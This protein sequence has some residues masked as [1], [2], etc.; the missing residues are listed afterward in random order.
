M[1]DAALIRDVSDK[2][3]AI[4][5]VWI[6]MSDGRRLAARLWLPRDAERNPVPAILEYIPYR[7]RD[8]TRPRDE[9]MHPW[10]AAQGYACARVDIAGSGD[11]D[12]LLLDEYLVSEQDDACEIIA[13][14]AAQPWCSGAVGM[15]G[16]SWGGFNGLQVAARRPPA[17]KAVI[18]LCSTVDR[19]ADDVH[20]M[21]GCLLNDNMDWGGAFFAYAALPPDPAM[22][23]PDWRR[24]W[25]ERLEALRPFPALW[26]EHQRRDAFWRHG[27]VCEDYAAIE[28][29]VL[30]VSG[31]ADGYTA[32]VF[33][34]VENLK[35]P[36]KGI[37]GPWGHLYP[38]RG[39]PGPAIGFLQ[40]AVRW[41]DRWLKNRPTGV[42]K[43][44]A[45]RLW[46][47]EGVAPQAHYDVRPGRWIGL[48]RWPSP[49]IVV[50][51]LALNAHGLA[52]KPEAAR[53]LVLCSPQTTGLAAGEWCAYGLGKVAP[54]MPLDQRI[55]DAGSLVFDSE[56]LSEPLAVVGAPRVTLELASDRPQA[57][58]AVRLSDVA[59]DGAATRVAYGLLNLS[60]RDSHAE[61]TALEPGRRYRVNV[62]L[63][64]AAYLFAPGRRLRISISTS[65][66]PMVWPS[67]EP[68]TLTLW[69]GESQLALPVPPAARL[70]E[71]PGFPPVEKAA[72]MARTVFDPGLESR[73]V[74]YDVE[75]DRT[76]VRNSRNDG[77]FGI[78]EIGTQVAYRKVK[79][80]TIARNDPTTATAEVTVSMHYR[81][82]DWD[83]R[84]ETRI[85]MTCD[86]T[87]FRFHSDV[88]AYA[89]GE[90]CFSRSFD[91]RIARDHV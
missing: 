63:T 59:P 35:A 88:D 56:P 60:H 20:F 64:E 61:P 40:E 43:D 79:E 45:L 53:A 17:L 33:R 4:E 52:A 85:R 34:L 37:V 2:V 41:W 65:Y 50:Q 51:S 1:T 90:R 25:L 14:L 87:H 11:S 69:T 10:V 86:R 77:L 82:E 66:W 32:A 6:P 9:E 22:V 19:Y 46:L 21:G 28:C 3:R 18:S 84:L 47:Q 49:D 30:G 68:A 26:L 15:I 83:A 12:G 29:P 89:D 23:G 78:D 54:E 5:L 58:V 31:W 44:P 80:F 24:R 62:T 75:T 67:P 76:V 91:H 55:D 36:S 13:W 39:V 57:L 74:L 71:H 81:R 7:R 38:Q 48:E 70:G 8:G 27:S 16:I 72:P 42:E 73:Q